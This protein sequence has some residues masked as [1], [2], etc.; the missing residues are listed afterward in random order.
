MN[1]P[2]IQNNS[3]IIINALIDNC[4]DLGKEY[5]EI[6]IDALTNSQFI[7]DIPVVNTVYG[8]I[9]LPLSIWNAAYMKKLIY[10]SYYMKDIPKSERI[11]FVNKAVY[12]DKNF[13]ESLMITLE[14]MDHFDKAQLLKN[15]FR[16]YGHRDGIDYD[17]YRRFC[18]ILN[19]TYISDLYFL[20]DNINQ[21]LVGGIHAMALSSTGLTYKCDYN[22]GNIDDTT[23]EPDHVFTDLAKLFYECVFTDKYAVVE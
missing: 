14:K 7:K 5:L 11:K 23:Q 22:G 12:E 16:A 4:E 9:K 8:L 15:L 20:R 19:Q 2:A 3:E 17:T 1:P 18:Y 13:P 10:F 21:P 6:G